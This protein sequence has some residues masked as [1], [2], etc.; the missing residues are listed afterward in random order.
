MMLAPEWF[1]PWSQAQ[2]APSPFRHLKDATIS[3]YVFDKGLQFLSPTSFPNV[4]DPWHVQPTVAD[5]DKVQ[6]SHGGELVV[7]LSL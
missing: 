4:Q 5:Q 1:S 2:T 7:D 6:F 3:I